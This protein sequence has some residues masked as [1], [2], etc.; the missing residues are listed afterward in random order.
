MG[1]GRQGAPMSMI[2]PTIQSSG[3]PPDRHAER[4]VDE[5]LRYLHQARPR[6][7]VAAEALLD[8]RRMGTPEGQ[9]RVV[10]RLRKAMGPLALDLRL[11]PAKRGKY[12]MLL[13]DWT[14]WDPIRD[15]EVDYD[16]PPP[17]TAWLAAVVSLY[18][19]ANYIPKV[20]SGERLLLSRHSIVRLAQRADVRTVEDL[21][22]A[23]RG[24][25]AAA[26]LL[27]QL[28]PSG[29]WLKP[30]DGAWLVPSSFD[31]SG[32]VAVFEPDSSGAPRLVVK[33]ILDR[34]MVPESKLVKLSFEGQNALAS[35][36]PSA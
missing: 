20:R 9:R 30:P 26:Y 31:G 8:N 28:K 27:I 23:L 12:S 4:V 2:P 29:S 13:V 36:V 22:E 33:T 34:A 32:P 24:L 11:K 18:T 17:P 6:L 35:A 19:G 14:I 7:S 5:M 3:P 25:W 1:Q 10:A 16:K 21:I 15:R